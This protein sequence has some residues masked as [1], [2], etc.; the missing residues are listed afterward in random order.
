[1]VRKHTLLTH[2]SQE[3]PQQLVRRTAI[4]TLSAESVESQ[5][6]TS[7]RRELPLSEVVLPREDTTGLQKPSEETPLE[8]ADADI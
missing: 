8:L 3:E 5:T 2:F 7:R 6:S 4:R 1:M